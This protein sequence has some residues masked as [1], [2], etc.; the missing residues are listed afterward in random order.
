MNNIR[1]SHCGW[2]NSCCGTVVR[3]CDRYQ[4]GRSIEFPERHEDSEVVAVEVEY[5]MKILTWHEIL[6]LRN[7]E[8]GHCF[9]TCSLE[10]LVHLER[11]VR[12]LI[13]LM[14]WMQVK[15]ALIHPLHWES[16]G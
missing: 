16:L 6:V 2:L 14:A 9:V 12:H 3:N 13:L 1:T 15:V 5:M 4:S 8:D 7:L 11:I 10:N